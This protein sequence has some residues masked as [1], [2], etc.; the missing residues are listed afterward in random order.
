MPELP[1]T[2]PLI[3]LVPTPIG[4]LGDITYRAVETLRACD[5]IAC[6]DTRQ[7]RRLFQQYGIET[8]TL[9]LHQHNEHQR[10]PALLKA[11]QEAPH[12]LAVVSD[13][14]M[15]GISDPGF[16]LVRAAR[17]AGI[18][19]EVLPGASAV[20]VAVAGS[21]LPA[22]RWC[23]EGFLPRKKGR[24][25][26][27]QELATLTQHTIVLFEAPPRLGRTLHDLARHLG[28]ERPACIARELSKLHETY[29][30]A[31]LAELAEHYSAHP[32]KGEIVLVVGKA[33]ASLE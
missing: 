32:P 20:P 17:K 21:G 5:R 24:Q 25:T 28:P 19:V 14:G 13:A 12:W 6:E 30:C 22:D 3:S 27:L 16:L 1:T 7:S 9:P 18:A 8:P 29:H 33:A 31:P 23:F 2:R 15:P 26:R 4:H 10:V 11:L